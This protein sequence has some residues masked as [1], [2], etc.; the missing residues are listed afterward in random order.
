MAVSLFRLSVLLVGL[1][2][3]A[4]I[5]VMPARGADTGQAEIVLREDGLLQSSISS[6]IAG[7]GATICVAVVFVIVWKRWGL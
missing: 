1:I 6:L 7:T 5:L 2:F 3:L 4:G